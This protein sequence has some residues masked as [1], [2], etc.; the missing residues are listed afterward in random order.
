MIEPKRAPV[1]P[2]I[3]SPQTNQPVLLEDYVATRMQCGAP[4]YLRLCGSSGSGKRTALCH[5]AASEL[6]YR[7]KLVVGKEQVKGGAAGEFDQRFVIEASNDMLIGESLKSVRRGETIVLRPWNIDDLIEYLLSNNSSEVGRI[8]AQCKRLDVIG[9]TM[10]RPSVC[11]LVMDELMIDRTHRSLSE[12][13]RGAIRRQFPNRKRY[14]KAIR[15]SIAG[16]PSRRLPQHLQECVKVRR[17]QRALAADLAVAWI[18]NQDSHRT[19]ASQLESFE[20]LDEIVDLAF[21]D[22]ALQERLQVYSGKH[23]ALVASVLHALDGAWRPD[24]A[25]VTDIKGGQF[26]GAMWPKVD[27]SDIDV[28]KTNLSYSNLSS[29]QG[30]DTSFAEADLSD[31]EL[32]DC[33]F[34]RVSFREADLQHASLRYSSFVACR[35]FSAHLEEANFSGANLNDVCFLGCDLSDAKFSETTLRKASFLQAR[36]DRIDF[37]NSC[38]V[39]CTFNAQD[40]HAANWS[41]S[42][43][44]ET[45]FKDCDFEFARVVG[46][47][48]LQCDFYGSDFTSSVMRGVSLAGSNLCACGLADVDWQGVD[49]RDADLR[50]CAFHLG[51]SRSGLVGSPYPGHGSKT[52][53]YTNEFDDIWHRPPEEIRR[54]NLVGADLRG[55]DVRQAD[56]YLVDLREAVYSL[57]QEQHFRRCDAILSD[58]HG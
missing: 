19:D 17:V 7:P 32:V 56:F 35:F 9:E 37:E 50:G 45:H 16:R 27:W 55:A 29:G 42:A 39:A 28:R 58:R 47:S 11:R 49:L 20:L 10:G 31:A 2:H 1:R 6:P 4:F 15:A 18:K 22:S 54:A 33:K 46:A 23:I 34:N 44:S 52:G 25:K 53:F 8:V 5:L 43:W 41:H 36:L 12:C 48:F 13:I 14:L 51:S 24:T 3:T 30:E 57:D 38:A 40:L 21:N 26:R